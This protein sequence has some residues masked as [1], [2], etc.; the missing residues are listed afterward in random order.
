MPTFDCIDKNQARQ[1]LD[2]RL[3]NEVK[4]YGL[5][6]KSTVLFHHVATFD[7]D[8]YEYLVENAS[9]IMHFHYNDIPECGR[10]VDF[11]FVASDEHGRNVGMTTY[12]SV[13]VKKILPVCNLDN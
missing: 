6:D 1:L 3:N 5:D 13:Q 2:A 10:Q 11:K 8:K 7:Y 4:V 9:R 12:F